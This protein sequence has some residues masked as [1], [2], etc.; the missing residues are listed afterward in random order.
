MSG[1]QK[2]AL[3]AFCALVVVF[4][5]VPTVVLVPM[6][7]SAGETLAFPPKGF[8]LRWYENL[9]LSPTWSSAA[10]TSFK[11]A[12][13]TTVVA[14]VLGTVTAFGLVRG[15]FPGRNLANALV[16]SPIIVPVV[17]VAI[18]MF[19]VFVSWRIAGSLLALILA[20]TALALPFV[21]VNV[22][23][24]LRTMD[25]DLESASLNLGA[26]PLTTFRYITLPAILPGV[27]AGALFAFI[28]S[29][30]EV[31]IAIF[32]TSPL[33]NTLPVEMFNQV[34]T[35]VDPTI[36]AL[37]TLLTLLTTVLFLVAIL[38]QGRGAN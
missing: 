25:R 29:W 6:S 4:L 21:V 12:L 16:L 30:D 1:V 32:L 26:G 37:A 10:I 15:R 13:G 19:A 23:A 14:T 2:T 8:S 20:H 22:S 33:V 11:V 38:L 31:V 9:Y 35:E 7:F 17:I 28:T 24:S 3:Y 18:A 36:A 5:I 34:R 27:L